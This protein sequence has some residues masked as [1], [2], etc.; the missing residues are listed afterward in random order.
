[1]RLPIHKR[2][3]LQLQDLFKKPP[4]PSHFFACVRNAQYRVQRDSTNLQSILTQSSI[5]KMCERTI[6]YSSVCADDEGRTLLI[7]IVIFFSSV[8]GV[9]VLL[10]CFLYWRFPPIQGDDYGEQDN[11]TPEQETLR[12]ERR[13]IIVMDNIILKVSNYAGMGSEHSATSNLPMFVT[14]Y[15]VLLSSQDCYILL[16]L[17]HQKAIRRPDNSEVELTYAKKLSERLS[18]GSM[19]GIEE[20]KAGRLDL[21]DAITC[22]SE[23]G[24][25]SACSDNYDLEAPDSKEIRNTNEMVKKDDILVDSYQATP[26]HLR[27]DDDSTTSSCPSNPKEC[28]I[29]M[30]RYKHN[31]EICWSR[32][33]RCVHAYH[34]NCMIE[35]LMK[36]DKCPMCRSNFLVLDDEDNTMTH[37]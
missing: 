21:P 14:F 9:V 19:D 7:T 33:E 13:R 16:T 29:C 2:A 23:E 5:F 30:A 25:Q 3:C 26:M 36:D 12:Q 8:V 20:E 18:N 1:M 32:N 31:D 35:W 34:L 10:L 22:N 24:Q 37:Y 11:L 6:K 28:A 15:L 17:F 4:P 27:I